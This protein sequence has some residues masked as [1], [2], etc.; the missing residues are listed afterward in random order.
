MDYKGH[1]LQTLSY[2]NQATRRWVP[3]VIITW[4]TGSDARGRLLTALRSRTGLQ[5][6]RRRVCAGDGEAVGGSEHLTASLQQLA[7]DA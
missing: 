5:E 3:K 6:D 1:R 4:R 7:D 2:E